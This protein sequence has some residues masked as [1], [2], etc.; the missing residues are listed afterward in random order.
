VTGV[1]AVQ[2][3]R[4]SDGRVWQGVANLGIKPSIS[5]KRQPLLE[6]H[7]FDCDEW[8]YGQKFRVCLHHKLRDE[9]HFSSFDALKAA[10]AADVEQARQ[11]WAHAMEQHS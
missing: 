6:A 4:L 8:L 2:A 7:F 9:Q 5:G 11:W 3:E 10:I 1:F